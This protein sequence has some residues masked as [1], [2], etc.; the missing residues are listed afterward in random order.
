MLR[1]SAEITASYSSLLTPHSLNSVT[2]HPETDQMLCSSRYQAVSCGLE[3][4]NAIFIDRIGMSVL[5]QYFLTV[6]AHL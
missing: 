1:H 3:I 6:S 2:S 5:A 4:Q